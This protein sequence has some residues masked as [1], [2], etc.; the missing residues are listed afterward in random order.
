[1]DGGGQWLREDCKVI[2]TIP[3]L[4]FALLPLDSSSLISTSILFFL[5]SYSLITHPSFIR[6]LQILPM[7]A[8]FTGPADLFHVLGEGIADFLNDGIELRLPLPHHPYTTFLPIDR[9]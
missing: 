7:D 3:F 8:N 1:M 4:T 2:W 5:C 6:Q 9:S